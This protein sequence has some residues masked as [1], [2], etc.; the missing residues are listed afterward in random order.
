MTETHKTYLNS[1]IIIY[2]ASNTGKSTILFD[3]LHKL[4][5]HV[6]IPYVFALTASTNCAFDGV[7]PSITTFGKVDMEIIQRIHDRQEVAAR[8]Y[9]TINKLDLL[10]S[11][12]DKVASAQ[13]RNIYVSIKKHL[14]STIASINIPNPH[15][16]KVQVEKLTKNADEA[17]RRLYK[18]CILSNRRAFANVADEEKLVLDHHNLNPHC[19][20]ILDDC[21]AELKLFQTQPIFQKLFFQG[22][23]LYITVIMTLQ[24]DVKLDS[25]LKKNARISIFTTDQ[26]ANAYFERKSN[27]FDKA[28]ITIARE[29]IREI[30]SQSDEYDFTKLMYIRGKKNP[31]N[32][33][34]ADEH[35]AFEFGSP[36]L[37]RLE[38]EGLKRKTDSVSNNRYMNLFL[39]KG[40]T[41]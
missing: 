25:Q 30:M 2:G 10:H 31:F 18:T 35:V 12:F 26:C 36:S 4:K 39:K 37:W 14:R 27:S 13:E 7:I 19:I 41:K 28:T 32:K 6:V 24:D 1:S 9:N 34:L 33:I 8:I 20:I 40:A 22:R 15:K 29:K 23:H 21:G 5:N 16:R 17:L 3:I 11:M 38:K